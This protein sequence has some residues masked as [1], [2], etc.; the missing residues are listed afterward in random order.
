MD[1]V[2]EI[3]K[4]VRKNGDKAVKKYTAVFDKVELDRFKVTRKDIK[5]AYKE[6]GQEAITAL[7][8]AA[9]NIKEF[10]RRQSKGLKDFEYQKNGVTL[11][12]KIVPLERVGVYA[13]G[14]RYPLPSTA[15]MGVIPAKV[16]GVK[17]VIVCSPKIKAVTIV[18]SDLAGAEEIYNIGGVQAIAAMAY[19]TESIPKVDKVVGPGNE[20]VTAAKKEIFGDCGI[21]LLAGPSEVLIIADQG[22]DYKIIAADLL[23]QAEHDVKAKIILVSDSASL[24]K[25]VEGELKN[26]LKNIDT[27]EVAGPSLANKRFVKVKNI[28]KAVDVANEI[29]P[30]HLELQVKSPK[31]YLNKLKNYGSLFLGKYSGVV[32]GDYC[33]GTNHILPTG[34][35][36]KFTG[37]LSVKG[38]LKILTYQQLQKRGGERLAETA[39]KL[40]SVEG[41][42]AHKKSVEIRFDHE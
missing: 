41:L 22:A 26:Q 28:E 8:E 11:G 34:G 12:Q 20:Y 13:P 39:K 1:K 16:A 15:L 30:E 2:Q 40:A 27:R 18:A 37:G 24:L 4:E 17:D 3:I 10:A 19:G 38:F 31:K 9:S 23:A 29:A 32:F 25:E 33:S 5:R 14:G 7:K 6:T 35:S 42:S 21:D 36:A